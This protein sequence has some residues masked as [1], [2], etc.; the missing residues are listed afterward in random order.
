MSTHKSRLIP[1]FIRVRPASGRGAFSLLLCV[2]T[3]ITDA[4]LLGVDLERRYRSTD[5]D[6]GG[7]S[8]AATPA[9]T[10]PI[11]AATHTNDTSVAASARAEIS[12]T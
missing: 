7:T 9:S 4:W 5:L 12:P 10:V 1:P 2:L 3:G 11:S 8:G 6:T